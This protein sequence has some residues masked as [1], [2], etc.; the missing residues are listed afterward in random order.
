[1]VKAQMYKFLIHLV[2]NDTKYVELYKEITS[3]QTQTLVK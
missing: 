2:V 1:M 3:Q